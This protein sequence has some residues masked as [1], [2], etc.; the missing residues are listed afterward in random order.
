MRLNRLFT[1]TTLTFLTGLLILASSCKKDISTTPTVT[2]KCDYAPYSKG[3]KFTY[4]TSSASQI[5]TDTITGD[6][7][8]NGVGYA[9]VLSTGP[10]SSG[11]ASVATSFIRC[12]ANGTYNLIDKAQVGAVGVTAF[13]PTV[14]QGIKLPA[15]VGL[16]WKSDTLKYTTS[17]GVNVAVL[18]KMQITALGGSKTVNGTAYANNLVTVQIKT[19][20]TISGSGFFSVDSSGVFSGVYDKTFGLIET[21]Q[22]GTV[23]KSLKTA[24]IK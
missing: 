5:A 21:A 15:S 10:S 16:A 7:T 1:F 11:T 18:Y 19:V 22:N 24:L 3:S 12:D 4:T 9:K 23:S 17:Q 8:I 2:S 20:T 13:T 6:T 14:L